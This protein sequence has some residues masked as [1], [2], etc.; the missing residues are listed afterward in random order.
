MGKFIDMTGW[1]MSEHGVKDSRLTVIKR[2]DDGFNNKRNCA[3]WI[4][5]CSCG[6]PSTVI[7]SGSH[8][9]KGHTL[10]C[11]C[12]KE[13]R[14]PK[15]NKKSN[16]YSQ[17]LTD[18]NGEYYLIYST[19]TS[20]V[21]Y[22][23]AD[24]LESV[25]KYCWHVDSYGYFVSQT[26][27]NDGKRKNIKMHQLL[28]DKW[29]DH[30]DRNKLNNRKYNIRSCTRN[31]NTH[32]SNIRSDNSSGYIGV[33]WN[34]TNNRWEARIMCNNKNIFLGGFSNKMDALIARLNAEYKYFGFE[35]APQR[36]LF[37]QYNIIENYKVQ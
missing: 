15:I 7:V 19:N 17:K 1:I 9:R 16:I 18:E 2:D 26:R 8:L 27:T 13:C 21:G 32:N 5:S 33:S 14:K 25:Q 35:F 3:H 10:S 28:F 37:K 12:L 30:V 31:D 34:K 36:H 29:V 20:D 6:N 22:I 24:M 4:C 11:G 23:D